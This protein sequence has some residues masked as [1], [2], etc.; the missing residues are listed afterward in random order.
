MFKET[1]LS[2][3]FL[4]L[5]LCRESFRLQCG[6]IAIFLCNTFNAQSQIHRISSG[7]ALVKMALQRE[8]FAL[9]S[10][11]RVLAFFL[12]LSISYWNT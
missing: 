10:N 7:D 12:S 1:F 8:G 9:C 11:L 5:A 3:N 4:K 6:V 2:V